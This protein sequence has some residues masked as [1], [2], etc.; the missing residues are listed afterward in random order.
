MVFVC[1]FGLVLV[2]YG[3][4]SWEWD[5]MFSLDPLMQLGEATSCTV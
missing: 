3:V 2:G 5:R 1:L 4:C